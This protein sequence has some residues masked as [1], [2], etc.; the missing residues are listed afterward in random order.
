MIVAAVFRTSAMRRVVATLAT[1][2][3]ACLFAS[4]PAL[5]ADWEYVERDG[6]HI[7]ISKLGGRSIA[8]AC[9]PATTLSFTTMK[10]AVEGT[11]EAGG[12]AYLIVDFA[13]EDGGYHLSIPTTLVERQADVLLKIQD[14]DAIAIA[15]RLQ[16][17]T[18]SVF[19]D[20]A[21]EPK[22]KAFFEE[23]HNSVFRMSGAA[24]AIGRAFAA[25][26]GDPPPAATV[27]DAGVS[28]EV[29]SEAP[30]APAPVAD[31]DGWTFSSQFRQAEIVK[32]GHRLVAVCADSGL[33]IFY[34]VP[35]DAFADELVDLERAYLIF[36]VD[37]RDDG[38]G[39]YMSVGSNFIPEEGFQ[40]IGL[41]G[42]PAMELAG[43]FMGAKRNIIV[44]ISPDRPDDEFVKYS[45]TRFSAKGSTAA[46]KALLADCTGPQQGK[47]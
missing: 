28:A 13:D 16:K 35:L 12:E 18:G 19:F 25:C 6:S 40:T 29:S 2:A 32:D 8:F 3:A 45:S 41:G 9:G 47:K 15:R 39:R 17:A 21:L 27:A 36:T 10:R 30:S 42:K 33:V 7:A 1:A 31:T 11:Y 14:D 24:D 23:D 38:T 5:A 34:A 22:D 43:Q 44:G 20:V 26:N 4:V 37:E 46:L